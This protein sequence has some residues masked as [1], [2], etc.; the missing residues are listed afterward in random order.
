MSVS[1]TTMKTVYL[2][3]PIAG[4]NKG[5]ANDW[6][7][8][9]QDHLEGYNIRGIS[10]L[11]CEPL[12]GERYS[13]GYA[14][15]KFGTARAI[16]SK[17][18][19]DVQNCDMTLCYFPAEIVEKRPSYGTVLELGWAFALRR[20]TIVVTD[21]KALSDHPVVSTCAGWLLTELDEALEVI[22]GILGDYARPLSHF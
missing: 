6:R 3:G 5:E 22:T 10:P 12:I 19:A 13:V 21:L 14:D 20:P 18:F 2:A 17:N 8:Y 15:P 4:C 9:V 11:R 16:G 1:S 7:K